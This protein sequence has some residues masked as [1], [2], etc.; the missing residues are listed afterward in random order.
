ML[1]TSVFDK[2][3]RVKTI[4]DA[5]YDL[6]FPR[7]CAS[8]DSEAKSES[9]ESSRKMYFL[10]MPHCLVFHLKRFIYDPEKGAKKV[11]K[12]VGY[13]EKLT[14]HKQY[15]YSSS[16]SS[17]GAAP[18]NYSLHSVIYHHGGSAINGHYT[19][20]VFCNDEWLSFNDTTI[21][22]INAEDVLLKRNDRQAYMLFYTKNL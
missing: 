3:D 13:P 19:C 20:D 7:D 9:S 22:P 8:V 14:I 18:I 12:F 21:S 2:P 17:R 10:E 5:I 15:L 11:P 6:I 16:L 4:E 1:L